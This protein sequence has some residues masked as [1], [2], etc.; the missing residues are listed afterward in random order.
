MTI[1]QT[2]PLW[3]VITLLLPLLLILIGGAVR[4]FYN[5]KEQAHQILK[6][7][8]QIDELER[9]VEGKHNQLHLEIKNLHDKFG[10]QRLILEAIKTTLELMLN[11]KIRTNAIP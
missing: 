5:Q 8:S 1:D 9:D 10:E 11:Q 6:L 7:E 3:G 2:I 4:M